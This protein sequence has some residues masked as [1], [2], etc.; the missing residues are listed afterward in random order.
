MILF[1]VLLIL[2]IVSA[3]F[4]AFRSISGD[5]AL[6]IKRLLAII[7]AFAAIFAI[8]FPA[9]LTSLANFF[10]IGRGVDLLL[11]VFIITVILFSLATVRSKARHEARITEL[12]RA[13]AL[14]E[15]RL[16]DNEGHLGEKALDTSKEDG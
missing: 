6:A 14:M 13:L 2:S 12:A 5:R 7:F 10:G 1:Q 9:A 11:Y 16:N 4:L 3:V 8:L 15:A